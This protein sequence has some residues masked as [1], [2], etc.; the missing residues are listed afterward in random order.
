MDAGWARWILEQFEYP[1]ERVFA[2]QLDAGNLNA[3]YST[4]IFVDGSLPASASGSGGGG[5]GAGRGG[6]GAAPQN[7][8]AEYQSQLGRVT[9]EATYPRLKEFMEN[10]G[11]IVAIGQAGLNFAE[12][13]KLPIGSHLV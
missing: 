8:P 2:P 3:K 6:G 11:T 4:L 1:F 13:L 10:G 7:I 9:A 12:W 5:R